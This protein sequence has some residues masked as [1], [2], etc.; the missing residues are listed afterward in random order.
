MV[1]SDTVRLDILSYLQDGGFPS[2]EVAKVPMEP[3]Q[4]D[5]V[6]AGFIHQGLC[7][8]AL[9]RGSCIRMF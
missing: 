4:L 7:L 1:A 9:S 3:N 6:C 2:N 8:I 5:A